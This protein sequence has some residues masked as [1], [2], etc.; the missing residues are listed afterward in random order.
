MPATHLHVVPCLKING[1]IH[2]LPHMPLCLIKHRGKFTVVVVVVVVVVVGSGGVM[3]I[4]LLSR[5]IPVDM[6]DL[7]HILTLKSSEIR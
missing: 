5:F 7:E 1:A 2:P 4:V 3:P 6:F